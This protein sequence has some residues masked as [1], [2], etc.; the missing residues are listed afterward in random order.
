MKANLRCGGER[1][2]CLQLTWKGMKK[3]GGRARTRPGR[4]TRNSAKIL[5]VLFNSYLFK[6]SGGRL[7][8]LEEENV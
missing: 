7:E 5:I 2:A 8:V 6:E 1:L 4:R 3:V